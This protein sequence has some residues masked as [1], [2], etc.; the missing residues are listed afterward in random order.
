GWS[1]GGIVGLMVAIARPDLVR[2]LVAIGTNFD[3]A[4]VAPGA[5]EMLASS[6]PDGP[7]MAMF[8]SLY[9]MHSPD[10]PEHWPVVFAKFT[11]MVQREPHIPV[12]DLARITAPTLL[13]I[14]DDD[15]VSLEH[16]ADLV[17]AI[18]D[19]ELA[20]VPRASHAVTMEKADLVN[21]LVLEFLENE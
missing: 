13:L 2:K 6:T 16:T 10:G 9:E 8:R 21:R 5:E 1:D 15:L 18:P 3:T 12:D 17:R 11:E 19:S 7:E 20:V 4:G 14:G